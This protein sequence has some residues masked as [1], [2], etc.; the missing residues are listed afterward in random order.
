MDFAVKLKLLRNK[1][2]LTLSELSEKVN[3]SSASLS[4]YES[5]LY[6]PTIANLISL[7]SFYKVTTDFLL[8][9]KYDYDKLYEIIVSK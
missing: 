4:S 3:I 6:R 9:E 7:A 5:E 8:I 1:R 2:G